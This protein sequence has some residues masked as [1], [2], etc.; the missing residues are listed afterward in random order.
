MQEAHW[1]DLLP[2]STLVESKL[3]TLQDVTIDTA[4][5]TRTAGNNGVQATS[6]ELALNGRL[7]LAVGLQAVSL[8]RL[9]ALALLDLL[10]LGLR[11]TSAAQ[12]LAVVSLVPLTERCSIDL[13]DGG[14]GEGVGSDQLVVGRVESHSDHAD[15]AGNALAA[16]REVAGVETQSTEFAVAA[17]SAHQVNTLGADTGVGG[18]TTLL[19]SSLLAIVCALSTR[20]A[21]LVTGV[22]RD[23]HD[24]GE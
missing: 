13:D 5:L 7:N 8:L 22:T 3:L 20:G 19:E 24:C 6:L 11:L 15:L 1:W 4:T 10:G 18:L 2:D 21:A 9:N 12:W 16:P 23:T 17:T 14:L